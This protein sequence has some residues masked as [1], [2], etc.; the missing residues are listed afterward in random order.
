MNFSI[1]LGVFII[2]HQSTFAQDTNM[3][4]KICTIFDRVKFYSNE[5]EVF[6]L[7]WIL[8]VG[9]NRMNYED[10]HY[11]TEHTRKRFY[12]FT[13]FARNLTKEEREKCCQEY[14]NFNPKEKVLILVLLYFSCD[15]QYLPFFVSQIHNNEKVEWQKN[16][17]GISHQVSEENNIFFKNIQKKLTHQ[18]ELSHYEKIHYQ[19]LS[20]KQLTSG[21]GPYQVYSISQMN[22]VGNYAKAILSQWGKNVVDK[23]DVMV[24]KYKEKKWKLTKNRLLYIV[25]VESAPLEEYQARLKKFL[26]DLETNSN[27]LVTVLSIYWIYKETILLGYNEVFFPILI[28]TLPNYDIPYKKIPKTEVIKLLTNHQ[29]FDIDIN[30]ALGLDSEIYAFG[31][32]S[33]II[34]LRKEWFSDEE[35]EKL[36]SSFNPIAKQI[37]QQV[38]NLQNN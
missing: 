19:N 24:K 6:P 2:I 27:S 22:S 18:E 33:E 23:D 28:D 38:K 35:F 5:I 4:L 30:L 8:F 21:I 29:F 1:I 16:Y 15:T 9:A 13:E 36:S 17:I 14:D 7:Q 20:K 10:N 32:V 34:K 25:N 26:T 3:G 11:I 37:W 31:L 12:Q